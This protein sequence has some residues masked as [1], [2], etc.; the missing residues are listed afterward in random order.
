MKNSFLLFILFLSQHILFAQ[1]LVNLK[2]GE[3]LEGQVKSLQNGLLV[4]S[5]KGNDIV[6][7]E[8]DITSI[9]FSKDLPS[10]EQSGEIKG[11]VTYYFNANYG[12]K[13]DV[14]ATIWIKPLDS[15]KRL[16]KLMENFQIAKYCTN[17]L[18]LS[19]KD[20]RC[21]KVLIELNANTPDKLKKLDEET[22]VEIIRFKKSENVIQL[23]ADGSGIYST[24]VSN[25]IY[26]VLIISQ[27]R[28]GL[29]ITEVNGQVS[30][31]A[32]EVKDGKVV[33]I[34]KKFDKM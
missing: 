12:D 30:C 3:K 2:S 25:G 17:I 28:K 27:G 23:T 22:L 11:V 18:K 4:L 14:G 34:N 6:L 31:S 8:Q 10:T 32:V 5:F 33:V 19:K 1:H 26:E 21:E 16:D 24:K 9:I 29:S 20:D 15:T 13:P 7:K